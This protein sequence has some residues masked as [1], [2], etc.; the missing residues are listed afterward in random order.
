M[1]DEAQQVYF[2]HNRLVFHDSPNAIGKT[3]INH[4]RHARVVK[5][6]NFV[7]NQQGRTGRHYPHILTIRTPAEGQGWIVRVTCARGQ[8]WEHLER[9]MTRDCGGCEGLTDAGQK[10][11]RRFLAGGGE[12]MGL[13]TL[14]I[15]WLEA[16]LS[17]VMGVYIRYV[18]M[19]I[20]E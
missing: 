4:L 20:N 8:H 18:T 1:S 14:T 17:K 2:R 12:N 10:V 7:I 9:T 6:K 19:S 15:G 3:T 5:L 11:I 16:E 13:E